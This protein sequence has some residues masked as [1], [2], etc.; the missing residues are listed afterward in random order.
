[1]KWVF[2]VIGDA[3]EEAR[4]EGDGSPYYQI[5]IS[6]TAGKIWVVKGVDSNRFPR[7]MQVNAG[8][9]VAIFGGKERKVELEA[10]GID[11]MFR[12]HKRSHSFYL[13]S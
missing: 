12:A 7:V 5:R 6:D 2:D 9:T 1:M 13:Q 8:D 10:I 11:K 3:L 4:Q